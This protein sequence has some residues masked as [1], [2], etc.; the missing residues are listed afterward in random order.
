[1]HSK[2]SKLA[3]SSSSSI[4]QGYHAEYE[5][6]EIE[7]NEKGTGGQAKKCNDVPFRALHTRGHTA[8]GY[9][10]RI[11]SVTRPIIIASSLRRVRAVMWSWW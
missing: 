1:M 7:N 8:R 9:F 3:G 4:R 11:S 6:D 10:T 5:V 2:G